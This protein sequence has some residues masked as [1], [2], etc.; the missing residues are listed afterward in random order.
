MRYQHFSR[1]IILGLLATIGTLAHASEPES[2]TPTK[3]L[4]PMPTD[5]ISDGEETESSDKGAEDA[6]PS[7][8]QDCAL[9]LLQLLSDTEICLNG[10]RDAASVQAALPRFRE[11]SERAHRLA[12]VQRHLP[13]PTSQDL[14]SMNQHMERFNLLWG[15]IGDHIHRLEKAGL[16]SH[17]LR[18]ILHLAPPPAPAPAKPAEDATPDESAKATE[19]TEAPAAPS[20]AGPSAEPPSESPKAPGTPSA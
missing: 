7:G 12:E 8:H 3:P 2:P 6:L 14:I 16:V 4:P 18:D 1:R 15:A 17:E 11:L 9:A 5:E 13:E 20:A 10:C 19:S